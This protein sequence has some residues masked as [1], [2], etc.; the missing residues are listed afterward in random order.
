MYL[1]LT[2]KAE[3]PVATFENVTGGPDKMDITKKVLTKKEL[4]DYIEAQN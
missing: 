4:R 1:S 3:V 2:G